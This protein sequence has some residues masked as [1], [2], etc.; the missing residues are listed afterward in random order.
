[1]SFSNLMNSK[2]NVTR[3][4]RTTDGVGGWTES[5]ATVYTGM[6]CRIQPMSGREQAIYGAEKVV[7]THKIFCDAS[8]VIY[9]RDKVVYGNRSF[10]VQLVRDIDTM[11]HHLELEVREISI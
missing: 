3:P 10:D 2:V 4:T 9:E 1:M 6:P 11:G 5:F 8:Y 7:S